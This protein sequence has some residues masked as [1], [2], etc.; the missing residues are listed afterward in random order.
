MKFVTV[1]EEAQ[2]L[3]GS[4]LTGK[5]RAFP[6]RCLPLHTVESYFCYSI[7]ACLPSLPLLSISM[8]QYSKCFASTNN[9]FCIKHIQTN[10]HHLSWTQNGLQ[11]LDFYLFTAKAYC[12]AVLLWQHNSLCARQTG[13]LC[14][15][16]WRGQL[17]QMDQHWTLP[18][19]LIL[20]RSPRDSNPKDLVSFCCSLYTPQCLLSALLDYICTGNPSCLVDL[21][22]G[23]MTCHPSGM[24]DRVKHR[25]KLFKTPN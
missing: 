10:S 19:P 4:V 15:A 7:F 24:I 14:K 16:M 21:T 23:V 22:P 12:R 13:W 3:W 8:P 25:I 9:K 5:G 1:A 17:E 6:H 11:K 18:Q 20:G 2:E